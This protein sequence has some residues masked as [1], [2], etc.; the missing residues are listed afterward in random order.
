MFEVVTLWGHPEDMAAGG[1]AA[2][3]E[4]KNAGIDTFTVLER[5]HEVGGVWQANT[6]PGAAC[7]VPSIIYQF[8][9]HLKPNWSRRF[10]SQDVT[11]R[12]NRNARFQT[13]IG[14][15]HGAGAFGIGIE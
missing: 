8:S 4:L 3:L 9:G 10:G 7:D 13:Q 15:G 11:Q 6:Y 12:L 1:L 5:A 2:A 14:G